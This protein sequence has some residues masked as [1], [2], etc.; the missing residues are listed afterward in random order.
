MKKPHKSMK[1]VITLELHL[2]MDKN[3]TH[4]LLI[5]WSVYGV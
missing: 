3:L 4:N 1:N 5:G 2:I